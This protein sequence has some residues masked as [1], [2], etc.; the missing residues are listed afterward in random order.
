VDFGSDRTIDKAEVVCLNDRAYQY[1]IQARPDGGQYS[2]I[3]DRTK[4]TTA[5]MAEAPIT[6]TFRPIKARY[7]KLTVTGAHEYEGDWCSI[8]EFRVYSGKSGNLCLNK[9]SDCSRRFGRTVGGHD[10]GCHRPDRNPLGDDFS[11]LWPKGVPA[12]RFYPIVERM[13]RKIE[14]AKKHWGCTLIY[15]DTNGVRRPVGKEQ[16]LKWTLLDPHIWREIHKRHPDVLLIPEFAPNPGQ[17]AYTTTYLQPPYSSPVTKPFWRELLP[18][19]FSVSYTVNLKHE[20][21]DAQ[22]AQF[23]DGVAAG[24]SLFFR[25]WFGCS[26]NK[27]VKALYDEVY[28][29]KAIN[30]G[31]PSS[32]I[33]GVRSGE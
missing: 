26:Y 30:P 6:D 4:N 9:A 13:C 20:D 19:A 25:G 8:P 22:R 32:Y 3:V 31:L 7:V 12:E 23:L 14:F 17:L 29:P 33:K 10:T 24:D 5:G 28:Q 11:R 16:E 18:G 2:Q 27:K 21:W 1:T 15:V